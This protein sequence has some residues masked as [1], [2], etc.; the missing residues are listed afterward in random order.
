M[1][2][3]ISKTSFIEESKIEQIDFPGIKVARI[4][5]IGSQSPSEARGEYAEAAYEFVLGN[6]GRLVTLRCAH[7]DQAMNL[8][9][10]PRGQSCYLRLEDGSGV[11][12]EH[13]RKVT[14]IEIHRVPPEVPT[15]GIAPT[16]VGEI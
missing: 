15:A 4:W 10:R 7:C 3:Q 16:E 2:L 12:C 9:T 13:C 6:L 8:S 11:Q 5:T 14:Y 1:Y